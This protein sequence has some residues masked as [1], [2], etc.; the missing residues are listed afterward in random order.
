MA[1][2]K[3]PVGIENFE[4]IR[5]QGY[6]YIDKTNFI[7]DL[8]DKAFS[9]NLIT[10]PRRFGKTLMMNMLKNFFDIRKHNRKLFEGLKIS[11]NKEICDTWM[12]QWPVLFLSF[13]DVSSS[14]GFDEAYSM[15]EGTISDLCK[16]HAYLLDS[17]KLDV[18]DKREFAQLKA[19]EASKADIK[20]SLLLLTRMLGIY[21]DKK[22]ILLVDEYDVPLAKADE[23]GYYNEMLDIIRSIMGTALKSNDYLMF[24]VV[25]GCLRIAKESIF[26]GTNH[27]VSNSIDSGEFM[28]AF[29]FT[30][31]E[32]LE[33]LQKAGLE[34]KLPE[35]K[36]WYDGYRFGDYEMYCPWDV[37][38][39]VS[40]LLDN[41]DVHP[42]NY[43]KDTSHN[44]IIRR[45]I[46]NEEFHVNENFE[47]LLSG[48]SISVK[49]TDELTYDFD[50]STE[51]N[52]W[53]ILYLTG[54]LTKVKQDGVSV[55]TR[56]RIPNEEVKTIFA[57]TVVS[58]F[59]DTMKEQDRSELFDAWWNGDEE[60]I[61]QLVS[62]I[63]FD[64]ISY[65][66]YREDYYH[67]FI[68]GLF[69]GAGYN[70]S[71]NQ[72]MGLGRSDIS[73]KDRRN[74]RA[75]IIEA[76]RSENEVQMEKDCEK[77]LKQ[78]QDKKYAKAIEKGYKSVMCYGVAFFDKS[79]LV[80]KQQ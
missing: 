67:A 9:V 64:T 16:E 15:L 45:F 62:E 55:D 19:Q 10:R 23:Y 53:S 54:Y 73:V 1:G 28:A 58:W 78:I 36:R 50:H 2:F 38:N 32:V 79:C 48:G 49:I 12:N 59:Q 7:A 17:E 56:L 31:S 27:F 66:D 21:H 24:S 8:L 68:A 70:V 44:N 13:K 75:I 69:A 6:Y 43:W 72:E 52:F 40:R 60:K 4:I 22:V 65:Y 76:K 5:N 80:K 39:H 47:N 30:E 26:T 37:V 33:I 34:Q 14:T 20:R 77:A 71:S 25:T 29:G 51:D 74:R 35:M 3:I 63:L 46:G 61:T 41:S 57:D 42:G 11:E 18:D